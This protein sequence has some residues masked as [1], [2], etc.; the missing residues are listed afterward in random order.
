MPSDDL[1]EDGYRLLFKTCCRLGRIKE[2][3]TY[4]DKITNHLD[5]AY[6]TQYYYFVTKE[7]DKSLN[8]LPYVLSNTTDNRFIEALRSYVCTLLRLNKIDEAEYVVNCI[9]SDL[10]K[11]FVMIARAHIDKARGIT[12][13]NQVIYTA[14]QLHNYDE[15]EVIRHILSHHLLGDSSKFFDKDSIREVLHEMKEKIK[16]IDGVPD[17]LSD[18]YF[19]HYD[20]IGYDDTGVLNTIEVVTNMNTDNI[21]TIYP[22][23]GTDIYEDEEIK[24]KELK[25]ESQIDKF[26]KRYGK[27]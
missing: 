2:A 15:E 3:K 26:Y 22:L 13:N 16:T 11:P 17:G 27:K 14:K 7:Y 21:I 6:Y 18:K 24:P 12:N 8:S 4:L 25:K 10:E 1:R 20:S 5:K 19:V 23:S 9:G